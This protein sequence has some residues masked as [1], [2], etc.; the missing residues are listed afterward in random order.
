MHI[1]EIFDF[2]DNFTSVNTVRFRKM[3]PKCLHLTP[4]ITCDTLTWVQIPAHTLHY[5]AAS[6]KTILCYFCWAFVFSHASV[7]SDGENI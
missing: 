2:R 3:L 4:P 5:A 7:L 1:Q 6:L